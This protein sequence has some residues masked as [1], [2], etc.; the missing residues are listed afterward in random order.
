MIKK[1]KAR[2]QL[3]LPTLGKLFTAICLDTDS[4]RYHMEL[5]NWVDSLPNVTT[6]DHDEN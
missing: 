5:L 4:S 3:R 2:A 6:V 1:V